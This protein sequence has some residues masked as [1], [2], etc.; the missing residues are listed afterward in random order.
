[1][2][3]PTYLQA[4]DTI[5]I[6]ATARSLHWN[7]LTDTLRLLYQQGFQVKIASNVGKYFHRF[8]GTDAERIFAFQNMLDDP[9]VKAIICARGGYG[10]TRMITGL[11]WEKFLNNPKWICGYSDITA[12]HGKL[13]R[14]GVAS[15]HSRMAFDPRSDEGQKDTDLQDLINLLMGQPTFH[16]FPIQTLKKGKAIG[17]LVGGNLTLLNNAIGTDYQPDFQ[18]AILLIE[19]VDEY[20]YNIDRMMYHLKACGVL[21]QIAGLVVGSFTAIKD[22]E[23][24]FG[25]SVQEIMLSVAE[26]YR[27]PIIHV[28]AIGH[29]SVNMPLYLGKIYQINASSVDGSSTVFS[30]YE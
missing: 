9:E 20:L 10:T 3:V 23:P 8:A 16:H 28:D 26:S 13:N 15:I 30:I 24:P 12:L 2:I 21:A 14:L 18:G 29:G 27:F 4:G 5:G 6:G 19:D 25:Y 1:M 11:N 17:R 7:D 22:D